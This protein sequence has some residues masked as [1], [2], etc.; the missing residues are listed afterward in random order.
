MQVIEE[1][2]GPFAEWAL[3]GATLM[4]GDC[5]IDLSAEER[6][7]EARVI[8]YADRDCC[9]SLE[10]GRRYA[11]LIVI[12]PRVYTEDP[13]QGDEEGPQRVAV[14]VDPATCRLHLWTLPE[15]P[16]HNDEDEE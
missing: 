7:V 8:V 9:L 16:K 15:T 5:A 4:V 3:G 12:P 10:P 13:P 2:E 1:G 11:A 6:D 14:P